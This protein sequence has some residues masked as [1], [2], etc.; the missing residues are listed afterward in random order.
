[1]TALTAARD[2][3]WRK[4][5]DAWNA[6]T[7]RVAETFAELRAADAAFPA[8][9]AFTHDRPLATAVPGGIRFGALSVDL[10][11]LTDAIPTDPRLARRRR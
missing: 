3:A 11:A 10:A 8:W 6:T 7:R 5:A 9:D 4:M 1:M 2:A